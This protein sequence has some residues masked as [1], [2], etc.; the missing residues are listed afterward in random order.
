MPLP[1][2]Q[3]RIAEFVATHHL[4]APVPARLLDLTSE[5]G[6]LAKEVLKSSHYGRHPF[7]PTENWPGELAD[8]LFA[9]ICLANTTGVDLQIALDHA[10]EKYTHRL[11]TT[12][13]AGSG[14]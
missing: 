11:T 5:L 7:T 13:Q 2:M 14:C 10:L 8:A 6:E 1:A 12:G 4:E 3:Q 9:L